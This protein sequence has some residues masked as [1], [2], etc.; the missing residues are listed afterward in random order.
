MQLDLSPEDR[1]LVFLSDWEQQGHDSFGSGPDRGSA[2][3]GLQQSLFFLLCS[4]WPFFGYL[5]LPDYL[6]GKRLIALQK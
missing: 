4:C 5:G 6:L 1:K 2:I 3:T